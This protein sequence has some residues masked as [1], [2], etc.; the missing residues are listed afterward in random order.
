M[1][2]EH[3]VTIASFSYLLPPEQQRGILDAHTGR[4]QRSLEEP[5]P[6]K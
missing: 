5:R 1:A 2:H 3:A 4:G 6:A